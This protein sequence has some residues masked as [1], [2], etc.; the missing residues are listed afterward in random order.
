MNRVVVR[1]ALPPSLDCQQTRAAQF[2]HEFSDPGAAHPHIGCQSILPW[3][4]VV[5]VPC[6]AEEHPVGH[7]GPDGEIGVSED[8][9]GDL[10]KTFTCDRI[11]RVQCDVA[12]AD[13][14]LDWLHMV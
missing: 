10:S 7:P 3:K 6:V 2:T 9:I 4:A 5:I 8:E 13:D 14:F 11:L 1:F 12:F